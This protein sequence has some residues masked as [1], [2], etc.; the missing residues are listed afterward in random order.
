M[1][2]IYGTGKDVAQAVV[3]VNGMTHLVSANTSTTPQL[4]TWKLD[5]SHLKTFSLLHSN[6]VS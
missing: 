5:F 4:R 3:A 2:M 6:R 1:E